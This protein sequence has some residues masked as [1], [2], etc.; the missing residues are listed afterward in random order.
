MVKDETEQPWEDAPGRLGP[1]IRAAIEGERMAL[2]AK[3]LE[4]IVLRYGTFYGPGTWYSKEGSVGLQVRNRRFPIVG[5]GE[6]RFSFVHIDDA[7]TATVAALERGRPG[8]YNVCDDDPAPLHEWLP[9]FAEALE[10]KP[11]RRV[12]AWAARIIAGKRAVAMISTLRGAFNDKAKK[13][14][15][16]KLKYPSW[17]Q[18]FKAGLG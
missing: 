13:T 18:G 10:A 12:P 5:K 15:S 11:P 9:A 7:V 16:W 3:G 8:V 2:G 17:R 1:P 14:L 4:S 6:G